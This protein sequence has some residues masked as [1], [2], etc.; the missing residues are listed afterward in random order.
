MVPLLVRLV[1]LE[2]GCNAIALL[3]A[4]DPE[5]LPLLVMLTAPTPLITTAA[6]NKP[7]LSINKLSPVFKVQVSAAVV[8]PGMVIILATAAGQAA[9]ATFAARLRQAAATAW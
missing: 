1:R 8:I 6:R 5:M 3:L 4:L 2:L 9:K 7:A